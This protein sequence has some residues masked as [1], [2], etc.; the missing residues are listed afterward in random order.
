MVYGFT[1]L[2]EEKSFLDL[3]ITGLGNTAPN[4]IDMGAILVNVC[5]GIITSY[6]VRVYVE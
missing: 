2:G 4:K 3:R 5:D 6:H 1:M